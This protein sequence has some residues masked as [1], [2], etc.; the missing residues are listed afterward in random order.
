MTITISEELDLVLTQK[1]EQEHLSVEAYI[2][3]LIRGDDAWTELIE[4][5]L[6]EFDSEFNDVRCAVEEGL[7]QAASGDVMPAETYFAQL[8]TRR[9]VQS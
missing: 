3:Y 7:Q 1:A 5:P 4:D 6:N 2:E 9:A 8:R